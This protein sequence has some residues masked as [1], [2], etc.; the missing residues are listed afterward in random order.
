MGRYEEGR[1]GGLTPPPRS[2]SSVR[3]AVDFA[4]SGNGLN[5]SQ[6]QTTV[7]PAVFVRD[8]AA[9]R[10]RALLCLR[11]DRAPEELY[12]G[13]TGLRSPERRR[14]G[15]VRTRHHVAVVGVKGTGGIGHAGMPDRAEQVTGR[16]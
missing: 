7:S 15:H 6:S 9:A 1:G 2:A 14:H 4:A 10:G 13:M 8:P 16:H 5:A 3:Y 12:H 11:R